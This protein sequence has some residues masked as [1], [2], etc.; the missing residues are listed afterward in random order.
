[1]SDDRTI[2]RE[3]ARQYWEVSQ[4]PV[5]NERRE[6]WRKHNSLEKTRSPINVRPGS[7]TSCWP[8]FVDITTNP[9]FARA[10]PNSL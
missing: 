8:T 5:M 10:A 1:M 7:W 6:L 3:L 2:L 4:Q 9:R